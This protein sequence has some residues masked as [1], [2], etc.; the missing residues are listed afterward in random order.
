M[1]RDVQ[2]NEK[3]IRKELERQDLLRRKVRNIYISGC[4]ASESYS[5]CKHLKTVFFFPT[6]DTIIFGCK[7]EEQMKKD[8]EKQDRERK[9]EELRLVR[10][11]QRKEERFQ[12]EEKREMERRERFL[13]KELVRVGIQN[14]NFVSSL[15]SFFSFQNLLMEFPVTI[16]FVIFRWRGKSKKKSYEK[17]RKLQNRRLLWRRQWHEE[18][19]KNRWS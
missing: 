14:E 16:G 12:R 19:L 15:L 9:K 7:R 8:M 10:E 13:Q 11:R 2:T 1:G 4:V 17:R 18:L 3:R 5:K 6:T